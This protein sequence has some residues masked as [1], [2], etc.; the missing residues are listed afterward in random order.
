VDKQAKSQGAVKYHYDHLLGRVYSWIIGDFEAAY[1]SNTELFSTLGIHSADG[2]VAIDLGCGP[3]NQSVPLAE[4]GFN[5]TAIDFCDDLL[6]ELERRA[7]DLPIRVVNDDIRKFAAHVSAAPQLIV[8][9]GDTLVHL[10][11]SDSART[12]VS[13]VVAALC[14]G[15]IF[16]VSLRDY[17]GPPPKGVDRF[18]P[19]RSSDDRIF[20]CF[21]EFLGET[22]D[23]HDVLHTRENGTWRLQVSRYTKLCL[24]FRRVVDWLRDEGMEVDPHF[25]HQGMIVLRAVKPG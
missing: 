1:R 18:V 2:A 15:G 16:I 21:L 24:D 4:A 10:P 9:M 5:V 17:S 23:V 11:N 14:P 7:G 12:L 20:T 3:G 6:A 25:A 13:G 19:V 8:C 22:I